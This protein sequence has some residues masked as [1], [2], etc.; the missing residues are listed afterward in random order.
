[1]R[2]S[3]AAKRLDS[4]A[5]VTAPIKFVVGAANRNA[6]Y[7]ARRILKKSAPEAFP[8]V[9]AGGVGQGK[10]HLL[11]CLEDSFCAAN[12]NAKVMFF[13]GESLIEQFVEALRAGHKHQFVARLKSLHLLLIDDF[14]RCIARDLT[15]E[16]VLTLLVKARK[17]ACRIV[18]T[19][20]SPLQ[21]DSSL[22]KKIHARLGGAKITSL[23]PPDQALRFAILKWR[24]KSL[25]SVS[26]ERALRALA[27]RRATDI[28]ELEA[29]L[30]QRDFRWRQDMATKFDPVRTGR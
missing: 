28:R 20:R 26:D 14:D 1:M 8:L 30:Y 23:M 24:A 22:V 17:H 12:P 7:A 13:S 25:D 27:R 21:P 16:N 2:T 29:R 6:W 10:T 19:A 11:E 5:A 9:V 4:Q 15:F 18:V 3:S